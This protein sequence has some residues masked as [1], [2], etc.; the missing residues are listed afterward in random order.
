MRSDE[1]SPHDLPSHHDLWHF[2]DHLVYSGATE[3]LSDYGMT[4]VIRELNTL[5][6]FKDE[7]SRT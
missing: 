7:P 5:A 4:H 6:N 1:C 2:T 3:N